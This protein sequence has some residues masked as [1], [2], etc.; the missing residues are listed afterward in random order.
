MITELETQI[1][2]TERFQLAVADWID[3]NDNIDKLGSSIFVLFHFHYSWSSHEQSVTCQ[4]KK[5][6]GFFTGVRYV[7]FLKNFILSYK[8]QNISITVNR[9]LTGTETY[10]ARYGSS[11]VTFFT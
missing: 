1:L 9:N 11:L 10:G 5:V 2:K 4:Q 8:N 3:V 7:I 6:A